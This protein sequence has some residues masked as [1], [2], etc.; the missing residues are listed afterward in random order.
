M[1]HIVARFARH[2]TREWPEPIYRLRE[3]LGLR[4]GSNPIFDAKH[5]PH[6]ALALFSKVMAATQPD[7]P[8]AT[9]VTGFCFYDGDAGNISLP[10]ELEAFLAAGAPPLVFTLGSAAVMHAGDFY[11]QSARAA[12]LLEERAVLLV[13]TDERNLPKRSLPESI[14][15]APYAPYSMLFPRASVII[16]Q[17]GV[18]TTAQALRAGRPMLVMPYSHDQPDNARRVRRLGVAKVIQRKAYLAQPAAR[19]IRELMTNS[20]YAQR[21]TAVAWEMAE[22]DGV[23][24]ACDALEAMARKQPSDTFSE[25]QHIS[26]QI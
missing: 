19:M 6:L 26:G 1:G 5:A 17:G 4:R 25:R 8:S 22:E 16:H 18:G 24:A 10:P 20:V 3:E 11:E 14:C 15:V 2:V 23:R 7:W 9:K 13:G 21:A 12:E